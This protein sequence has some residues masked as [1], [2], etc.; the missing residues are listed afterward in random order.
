M[1][2]C[3][4]IQG[5]TAIENV[6]FFYSLSITKQFIYYKIDTVSASLLK[7]IERCFPMLVESKDFLHLDFSVVAKILRSSELNVDSEVEVVKAAN[8]WFQHNIVARGKFAKQLLLKIRV[9]LLTEHALNY[10]KD[11]TLSIT[12][13]SEFVDSL[14]EVLVNKKHFFQNKSSSYFTRRYCSQNKFN[15]LFCAG[16]SK[17]K[18]KNLKGVSEIDGRNLEDIQFLRPMIEERRYSKSVCVKGEVY[19]FCGE[20]N[21]CKLIKSIE[22]YSTTTR[23]WNIVADMLDNREDFCVCSFMDEIFIF[24]GFRYRSGLDDDD[25]GVSSS[26]LQFFRNPTKWKKVSSMIGERKDA[27]CAVFQ[28]NIVISGGINKRS[29]NLNTVESYDVFADKWSFMPNTI[30]SKSEH[31]LVVVK[32]KLFVIGRSY[33]NCEVFDKFC[34]EFVALKSPFYIDFHEA[35]SIRNKIIIIQHFSSYI[36][37]YDAETDKWSK[38]SFK[39]TKSLKGFSCAKLPCYQ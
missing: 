11:K 23:T 18:R 9:P 7:Y 13:N 12:E 17:N 1:K 39:R 36:A 32:N 31:S 27:A 8:D 38:K 34:K 28:G 3:E 16:Y 15:I 19:V 21:S 22:K 14:K 35:I 24:G 33:D 30:K 37:C 26:C 10:I 6:L 5:K 2:I 20:S 29:H 25:E 4:Y